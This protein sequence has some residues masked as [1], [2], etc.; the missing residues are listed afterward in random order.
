[1]E[2]EDS[3][4][5]TGEKSPVGALFPP[6]NHG[7]YEEDFE[8]MD[9]DLEYRTSLSGKPKSSTRKK[10]TKKSAGKKKI[11]A[12]LKR[13]SNLDDS[14][15]L[16]ATNSSA[17]ETPRKTVKME[18]DLARDSS[19]METI[20]G[21]RKPITPPPN[22]IL[23]K[24][25]SRSSPRAGRIYKSSNSATMLFIDEVCLLCPYSA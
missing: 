5:A 2:E 3:P 6:I 24:I 10:R 11:L 8:D 15:I 20:P 21:T 18:D 12:A 19:S 22:V 13:A 14:F 7:N 1:M 4:F 17:Q 16:P 25:E 9:N 23:A